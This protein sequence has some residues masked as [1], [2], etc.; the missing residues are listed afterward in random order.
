MNA[1][2]QIR[3]AIDLGAQAARSGLEFDPMLDRELMHMLSGREAGKTPSG[4]AS[5]VEILK[6]WAVAYSINRGEY[7]T[8]KPW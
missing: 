1:S 7:A 3:K 2:E 6:T 5:S 4:E 8:R